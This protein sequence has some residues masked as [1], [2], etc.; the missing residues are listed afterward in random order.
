MMFTMGRDVDGGPVSA[1]DRLFAAA[2]GLAISEI[3][4]LAANG[5]QQA[6]ISERK[7]IAAE[8]G[9]K[10]RISNGTV[11]PPVGARP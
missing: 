2:G 1:I 11:L 10:P 8:Q 5:R 6:R 4:G 9:E 7:V 3:S